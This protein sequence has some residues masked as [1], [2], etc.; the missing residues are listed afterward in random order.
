M[1]CLHS[2]ASA[3]AATDVDGEPGDDRADWRKVDLELF[4]SPLELEITAVVGV[5]RRECC[6]QL[7]VE[8]ADRR[9][10]VAVTAVSLAP[11]PAGLGWLLDRVA[12]RDRSGLPLA[13][14]AR[15]GEQPLQLGDTGV[16]LR[17]SG[18]ALREL[19][20]QLGEFGRVISRSRR[21]WA[22]SATNS[23]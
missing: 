1:P 17:K 13:R 15:L 12:L 10:A 22:I 2:L 7:V 14:T 11:L 4:S 8:R 18:L 3:R 23:L 9:H 16:A 19:L 20:A 6:G 21:S 5:A